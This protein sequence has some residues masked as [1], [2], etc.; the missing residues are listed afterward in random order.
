MKDLLAL[1]S[2]APEHAVFSVLADVLNLWKDKE[3]RLRGVKV[4]V[5]PSRFGADEAISVRITSKAGE[6][7]IGKILVVAL[8][9]EDYEFKVP[10]NHTGGSNLPELDPEGSI[11][12]EVVNQV[13]LGLLQRG[14]IQPQEKQKPPLGFKPSDGQHGS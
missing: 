8:T 6:G 13:L 12:D 10:V 9:Q 1:P 11:F 14:L 2:K 3:V 5:N 4:S 7:E